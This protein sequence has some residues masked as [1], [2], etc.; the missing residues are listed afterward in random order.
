MNRLKR[1]AKLDARASKK[2]EESF[3]DHLLTDFFSP[4]PIWERR[5]I[6]V[7]GLRELVKRHG[8]SEGQLRGFDKEENDQ[9]HNL[10]LED[11][12]VRLGCSQCW[13]WTGSG[14]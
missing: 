2:A 1:K 6:A 10:C 14:T 7:T 12:L 9:R 3:Y 11:L 4:S 8:E 13:P 5:H